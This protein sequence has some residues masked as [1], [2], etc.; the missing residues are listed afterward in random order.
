MDGRVQGEMKIQGKTE[1]LLIGMPDFVYSWYTNLKAS[2]KTAATCYDFVCKICNFIHFVNKNAS[3]VKVSDINERNVTEFFLS[4]QTKNVDGHMEFTSDSYQG[5]VWTCLNNFLDYLVKRE[6]IERNYIKMIDRPKNKDLDRINEHR[7]LLTENN[8]REILT[9][10]DDE[11][12]LFKRNRDRAIMMIFMTTGMRK[13]AL[14]NI[15]KDDIDF[16]NATLS[17]IDKGNKM[18]TYVLN[19]E[20]LSAI[21]EWL[22]VR[23]KYAKG[24]DDDHLFISNRGSMMGDRTVVDLVE[25][26]TKAAIGK[27]LSPHKLRAG[28]CSILYD[29]THDAEFVRRAVGHA[30]V[31]T[32][33]RYIVTKGNERKKAAEI[34]A[35]IL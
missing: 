11:M 35:S 3:K 25:K 9:R 8:F 30:N 13:T 12:N 14:I 20:T 15:M 19:D 21:E 6:M 32:T 24:S 5:S 17:I 4:I 27:S 23:Y 2:R 22:D 28:Y 34:M 29:K 1:R 10:I 26:Y 7:T 16:D 33:Q 18:H 31:A